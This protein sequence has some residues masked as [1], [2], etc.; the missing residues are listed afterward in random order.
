LQFNPQKLSF[1]TNIVGAMAEC[2]R[3]PSNITIIK[4]NVVIKMWSKNKKTLIIRHLALQQIDV[5]TLFTSST[6]DY[7]NKSAHLKT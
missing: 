3:M 2:A 1:L 7:E 6:L 4:V 5:L